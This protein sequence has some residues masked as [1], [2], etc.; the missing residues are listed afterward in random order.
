[1]KNFCWCSI[2]ALILL[3]A[4]ALCASEVREQTYVIGADVNA[5]G[6]ITATQIDKHVP[7]SVSAI[8]ARSV[9]QWQFEP[10][11]SG[12]KAVPAHT[13]VYTTLSASPD[14]SAEYRLRISYEGN[15][16]DRALRAHGQ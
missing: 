8:L 3:C 1:M 15:G 13:F 4:S 5:Q 14:A 10:A 12:S 2:G 7:A 16:H 6:Q 9:R 11:K